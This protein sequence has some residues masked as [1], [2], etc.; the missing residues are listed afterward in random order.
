M[1]TIR[2]SCASGKLV[3]LRPPSRRLALHENAPQGYGRVQDVEDFEQ[4]MT[5]ETT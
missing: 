1:T 4:A 5:N 2:T 3:Y